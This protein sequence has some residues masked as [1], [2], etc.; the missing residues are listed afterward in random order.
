MINTYNEE[1]PSQV[2]IRSLQYTSLK[3]ILSLNKANQNDGINNDDPYVWKILIFDQFCQES[4]STLFKVGNL[5]D[6]NVTLHLNIA[7]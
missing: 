1:K 4:L 2:D 6:E 7:A 5:R 3:R